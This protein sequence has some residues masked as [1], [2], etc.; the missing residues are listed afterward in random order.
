[1]KISIV[2]PV[3]NAAPY[4]TQAIESALAQ[5]ETA[6]VI[7]VE[8]G[9]TD[10]S[11]AVCEQLAAKYD[12]VHLYQHPGG[13]NF[14]EG[15]SRNLGIQNCHCEY[16]A[17]LDADD[18]FLPGRFAATSQVFA[19]DP[20]LDGV[21]EAMGTIVEGNPG[22]VPA[23]AYSESLVTIRDSIAPEDLL[24]RMLMP[25]FGHFSIVSVTV[26][27]SLL[28][29]IG[30]CDENI[31]LY[32]D[33]T[34]LVRMAAAGRLAAG[35]VH[36]PVVMRRIHDHNRYLARLPFKQTQQLLLM[37]YD[38]LRTWSRQIDDERTRHLLEHSYYRLVRKIAQDGKNPF[39]RRLRATARMVAI[40]RRYPSLLLQRTFWRFMLPDISSILH[41]M[42]KRPI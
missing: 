41:N 26:K 9:S 27:R 3:F 38:N 39:W 28:E 30:A 13:N 22:H 23:W 34:T 16:V 2:I 10:D 24:E 42:N 32:A 17:F 6:E 11:L 36:E 4:V 25:P 20:T 33:I 15:A 1:M 21:Y 40:G 12:R 7:L 8:D 19:A 37:A 29:R 18:Y 31:S 5:P 14:G 35:N